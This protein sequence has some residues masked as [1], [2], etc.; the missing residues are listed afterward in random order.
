[1]I[2]V[3]FMWSNVADVE[4]SMITI[5]TTIVSGPGDLTC[6]EWKVYTFTISLFQLAVKYFQQSSSYGFL[7]L[8]EAC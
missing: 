8:I 7:Y 5:C 4:D 3:N 1:M 2:N 6:V